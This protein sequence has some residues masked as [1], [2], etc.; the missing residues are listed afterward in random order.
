MELDETEET[1]PVNDKKAD[2]V[3]AAKLLEPVAAK[4]AK[5]EP[6]KTQIQLRRALKLPKLN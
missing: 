1:K 4:P 6:A 3:A 5:P 2:L